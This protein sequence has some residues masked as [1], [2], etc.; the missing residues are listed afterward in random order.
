MTA[1][2]VA[3]ASEILT[4]ASS[5]PVAGADAGRAPL[6]M[7]VAATLAETLLLW[8]L[9]TGKL[10]A[11]AFVI[12]HVVVLGALAVCIRQ[13]A[14]AGRDITAP[15]ILTIA[16]GATGPI[17]AVGGLLSQLWPRRQTSPR[18]LNEW[19]RR[20]AL[21]ADVDQ[22]TRL[23]DDVTSGRHVGLTTPPPASFVAVLERGTLAERQAALGLMARHIHPAYLAALKSA[24]QSSEPVIRVQ[25]AAV[26]TKIRP[27][28]RALVDKAVSDFAAG[29]VP[30][31]KALALASDLDA[32]V[33]CGL[34]DAGDRIRAETI[35]PRLRAFGATAPVEVT[36]V[37][38]A[39]EAMLLQQ[40]RFRELRVARRV[41]VARGS[42]GRVRRH[43]RRLADARSNRSKLTEAPLE[44]HAAPGGRT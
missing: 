17:G 44:P 33:A 21:S 42:M 15:M 26:A 36:D 31:T 25:A 28:L 5:S 9:A 37:S 10:P 2:R 39:Q 43:V 23:C 12:G 19:Y 18:L 22:I 24:L 40:G 8:L 38:P 29:R 35:S 16:V 7:S 11:T 13:I 20:I 3:A 6:L 14:A 34:L 27:E 1:P 32:C 4:P 30:V 41:A